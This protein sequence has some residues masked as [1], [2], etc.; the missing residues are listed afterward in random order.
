MEPFHRVEEA[1]VHSLVVLE[2]QE[3]EVQENQMHDLQ[4]EV[5]VQE[6]QMH[7][8]Q[9]EAEVQEGQVDDLRVEVG[10]EERLVNDLQEEVEAEEGL[11]YVLQG[12]VG[13]E[14]GQ[15]DDLWVEAGV[16]EG[17]VNDL[18][19]VV[20]EEEGLVYDLREEVGVE[21][22]Q[23]D[24][25][26][27]KVIDEVPS[28]RALGEEEA[29]LN[30]LVLELVEE[31]VVEVVLDPH[32]LEVVEGLP[33]VKAV[34]VVVEEAEVEHHVHEVLYFPALGEEVEAGEGE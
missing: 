13:V 18:Q 26:Q 31:G 4:E 21:E 15:V 19:E 8:L 5:G 28:H 34:E 32:A 2:V 12:E 25:L 33:H 1:E 30:L 9:G 27:E 14:E 7:D 6:G 10:V 29:V 22:G 23:E 3:V 24:D 11:A 17:Q 16:E 20:G